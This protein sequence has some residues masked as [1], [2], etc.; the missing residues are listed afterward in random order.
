MELLSPLGTAGP[1]EYKPAVCA[2]TGF[3][4]VI[5]E[6]IA[7]CGILLGFYGFVESRVGA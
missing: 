2:Y 6:I 4:P 5:Q 1:G 3:D 7:Y